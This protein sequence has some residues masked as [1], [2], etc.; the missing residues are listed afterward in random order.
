MKNAAS[1]APALR[2]GRFLLPLTRPLIMGVVNITPDS[3]SDGGAHLD[4]AAA[5]EHARR[6]AAEGADIIDLGGEST[7]PGA[8]PV[9]AAQELARLDPVLAALPDLGVPI[10]VDTSKPDVM[11]TLLD[12]CDMVNDVNAFRAVGALEAVAASA[13]ALCF[14]HMQG[15]PRT[16]Q[17][18]PRYDDVV[19]EVRGFLEGRAAAACRHGIARDRIVIDPGFGFGKTYEHNLELLRHVGDLA[20]PGWP[21][22]VGLSRKAMI[23]RM[24]GRDVGDRVNGSVAAAL[25]AVVRGARIV[26]VHDVR[27]TR[28]ALAVFHAVESVTQPP[29]A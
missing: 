28:D 25:L 6:L 19:A 21:V 9:G 20:A 5:I 11:R 1:G 24:T 12:R 8:Q 18:S 29:A 15:E 2:C 27:A 23:G 16:M 4:P 13:V 26:R 10:S 14:M 22:L 17:L 7:R 3:F